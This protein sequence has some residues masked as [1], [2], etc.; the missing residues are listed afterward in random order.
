MANNLAH[1]ADPTITAY[2]RRPYSDITAPVINSPIAL[3]QI[4]DLTNEPVVIR[5]TPRAWF[6]PLEV[7]DVYE[8]STPGDIEGSTQLAGEGMALVRRRSYSNV[9]APMVAALSATPSVDI[10]ITYSTPVIRR[11]IFT[12]ATSFEVR[13]VLPPALVDLGWMSAYPDY[14]RRLPYRITDVA[15]RTVAFED[16]GGS[17]LTYLLEPVAP[18]RIFGRPSRIPFE[19]VTYTIGF[20]DTASPGLN[21][22][23]YPIAPDYINRRDNYSS[24]Y[25]FGAAYMIPLSVFPVPE[26]WNPQYPNFVRAATP[27]RDDAN[28]QFIFVPPPPERSWGIE[29]DDYVWRRR[30]LVREGVGHI[31]FGP[32]DSGVTPLVWSYQY[33]NI[34][35]SK[36]NN[37]WTPAFVWR[38]DDPTLGSP[39][40]ASSPR[41]FSTGRWYR[42][43]S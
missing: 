26:G 28:N 43:S 35:W 2:R 31:T 34:I 23:Y 41:R 20:E 19:R 17:S 7:R 39:V 12:P 14:L 29:Y 27:R 4:R 8:Y 38:Y 10:P 40:V 9:T 21:L 37:Y 16:Q 24:L 15:M 22:S 13:P 3:S 11:H 32:V 18:A 33:P 30:P 36:R 5:R 25:P 1:V 42:S 6:E